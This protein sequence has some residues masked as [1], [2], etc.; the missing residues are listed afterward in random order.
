MAA[1]EIA[2]GGLPPVRR[3]RPQL[4]VAARLWRPCGPCLWPSFSM[5]ALLC[6]AWGCRGYGCRRVAPAWLFGS[7][8]FALAKIFGANE[9]LALCSIHILGV[10]H[11]MKSSEQCSSK[12]WR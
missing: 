10:D 3:L 12:P 2:S 1:A 6:L 11:G 4:V 7:F 9:H 5:L 8:W